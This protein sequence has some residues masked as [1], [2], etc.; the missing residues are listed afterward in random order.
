[1]KIFEKEEYGFILNLIFLKEKD[2][3]VSELEK[4]FPD[5]QEH[6]Q[7]AH[8]IKIILQNLEDYKILIK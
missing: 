3:Y 5:N 7:L 2:Q 6:H 8:S 1:M 4:Y